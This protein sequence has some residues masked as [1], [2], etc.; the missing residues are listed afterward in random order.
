MM[1][2]LMMISFAQQ[3]NLFGQYKPQSPVFGV[4]VQLFNE[5]DCKYASSCVKVADNGWIFVMTS[6]NYSD[7]Q[8]AEIYKS[9]DN[10]VTF[11]PLAYASYSNSLVYMTDADMVVT[12]N[13]PT[14][15]KIWVVTVT[16]D[17]GSGTGITSKCQL[18]V[19]D[20]LGTLVK[21]EVLRDFGP[22]PNRM[23]CVSIATDYRSPALVS[24]PFSI[25]VA[26]TGVYNGDSYVSYLISTDGGLT[27]DYYNL[28]HEQGDL[29]F[30]MISLAIGATGTY[31]DGR[32][33]IA[34]EK[35]LN[36][37]GGNIGVLMNT[38]IPSGSWTTPVNVN[39]KYPFT[40]GKCGIPCVSI[41]DDAD[42]VPGDPALFPVVIAYEDWS[43]G[44]EN[45]DMMISSLT[46]DYVF[47]T[48]ASLSDFTALWIDAGTGCQVWPDI[49]FDKF[50]ET[51]LLTYA[52]LA[53]GKLLY[54]TSPIDEIMNSWTDGVNYRDLASPFTYYPLP[55][56]DINPVTH[57]ASFS[58]TEGTPGTQQSIFFDQG[59]SV[60][61]AP[62]QVSETN[63]GIRIFPNPA[64]DRFTIKIPG[65]TGFDVEITDLE[66]RVLKTAG[67]I[68]Q[69]KTISL[70]GLSRGFYS[71]RISGRNLL[72]IKPLIIR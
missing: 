46:A 36:W 44:E 9:V 2:M 25:A 67:C 48:Q 60:T 62:D 22:M 41:M 1:L 72:E 28:W 37:Y 42:H 68:S 69:E 6:K 51:F 58:W 53:E 14:N 32:F 55:S 8:K 20:A 35:D 3:K 15:I 61:G 39:T 19:W 11:E 47:D 34:F 65:T 52:S 45:T 56:T 7:Y 26:F 49:A 5:P 57:Y 23:M 29:L 30:N 38:Y 10:G 54:R 4:D 63:T 17:N 24:L 31:N 59:E 50:N 33:V 43:G 70:E 71:V 21:N 18:Y 16:K 27:F 66:G 13:D 64:D 12:G 40:T